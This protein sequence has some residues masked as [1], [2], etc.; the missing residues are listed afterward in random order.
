MIKEPLEVY[1]FT[2]SL[3]I[4]FIQISILVELL[5]EE[6]YGLWAIVLTFVNFINYFDFGV[7]NGSRLEL[8]RLYSTKKYFSF[9]KSILTTYRIV[10]F[11]SIIIS[12]VLLI[13]VNGFEI[14]KIIDKKSIYAEFNTVLNITIISIGFLLLLKVST[15][16]FSSRQ[17]PQI[18]KAAFL[19]GQILFLVFISILNVIKYNVQLDTLVIYYFIFNTAIFDFKSGDLQKL[20]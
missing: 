17:K 4:T 1:F 18:E 2:S 12:A 20:C 3:I 19:I 9:L 8:T 7:I 15:V 13:I 14:A 6:V 5:G 11:V 10:F 16:I